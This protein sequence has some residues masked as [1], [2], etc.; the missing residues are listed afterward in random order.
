MLKSSAS[1]IGLENNTQTHS[2]CAN[3]L[4]DLKSKVETRYRVRL[5]LDNLPIT[6]YDLERG[7]ESVRPGAWLQ[8]GCADG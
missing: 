5:I 1:T 8:S 3:F 7:P 2:H 6:T 4:Q